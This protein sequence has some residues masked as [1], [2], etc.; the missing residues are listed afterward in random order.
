MKIEVIQVY[1]T[2]GVVFPFTHYFQRRVNE[3][4]TSLVQPSAEF[5]AKYGADYTLI[6]YMSAKRQ[7]AQTEIAGPGVFRKD[8]DVEY[9]LFLPFDE[10]VQD[11]DVQG[12]TLKA[13][14]DAI[15]SVL[16]SLGFDTK[17]L[18]AHEAGLIDEIK[19]NPKMY[20]EPGEAT[21]D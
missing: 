11:K 12:A 5:I 18:S 9:T 10:I 8:R 15:R 1:I 4:L 19:S 16:N 2:P 20:D 3:A 17:R 6:F 21:G 13:L 14:F 7:L